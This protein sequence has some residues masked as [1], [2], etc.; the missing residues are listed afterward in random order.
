MRRIEASSRSGFDRGK[1]ARAATAGWEAG[2]AAV[3]KLVGVAPGAA[4]H[5]VE[6]FELVLHLRGKDVEGYVR[7]MVNAVTAGEDG[8]P[9]ADLAAPVGQ[10][11]VPEAEV[12]RVVRAVE[13][14]GVL[15][16]GGEQLV[17]G[18]GKGCFS[19]GEPPEG[20]GVELSAH[21][22]LAESGEPAVITAFAVKDRSRES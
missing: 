12:R 20:K 8:A 18:I 21:L 19:Q 5:G 2:N 11:P 6:S 17:K 7:A 10:R 15:D 22:G 16:G 14:F 9:Q 4:P 1:E 13:L 3:E